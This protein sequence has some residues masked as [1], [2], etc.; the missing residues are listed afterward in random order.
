MVKFR[1]AIRL[2]DVEQF[3]RHEEDFVVIVSLAF[4]LMMKNFS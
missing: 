2:F 4:N 1:N 3:L